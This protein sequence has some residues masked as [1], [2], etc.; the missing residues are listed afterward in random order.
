M[1]ISM[2]RLND[3]VDSVYVLNLDKRTDRLK[4]VTN[5]LATHN[6]SFTRFSAVDG[7]GLVHKI[8]STINK[9]ELACSLSHANIIKEASQKN[10]NIICI[11]EDDVVLSPDFNS[12]LE[13]AINDLPPDWEIFYLGANHRIPPEQ[14]T[15]NIYR[16]KFALTTHAYIINSSIYRKL[17]TTIIE[18]INTAPVDN[19]LTTIQKN[20]N[21]YAI[22]PGIAFQREGHSDIRGGF[23]NYDSVL[24]L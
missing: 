17:Q 3:F 22:K 24:R 18:N 7:A 12:E 11:F 16:V 14:I 10:Q 8:S 2:S 9:N 5:E 6:I 15:G 20:G 21:V 13:K 1:L 19:I 23:R 4:E